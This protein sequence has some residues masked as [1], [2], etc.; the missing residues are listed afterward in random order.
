M[1]VTFYEGCGNSSPHY[2]VTIGP[3]ES[4]L[5]VKLGICFLQPIS[6]PGGCTADHVFKKATRNYVFRADKLQLDDFAKHMDVSYPGW[7][8]RFASEDGKDIYGRV[9]P[10]PGEDDASDR[11]VKTPVQDMGNLDELL[12]SLEVKKDQGK[13]AIEAAQPQR[14]I[15]YERK[16]K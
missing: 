16:A 10:E 4:F 1:R 11:G 9:V 8:E 3:H 13:R 14:D 5:I 15:V 12:D 6:S 7:S 2:I